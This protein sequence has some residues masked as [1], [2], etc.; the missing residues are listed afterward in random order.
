VKTIQ[1]QLYKRTGIAVV[2]LVLTATL[3]NSLRIGF[4]S[5]YNTMAETELARWPTEPERIANEWPLVES[6]LSISN[7]LHADNPLIISNLGRLHQFKDLNTALHYFRKASKLRPSHGM[8]W[9]Q[10]ADTKS[11]LNQFDG[12]F[13]NALSKAAHW[14]PWEPNAQY[15]TVRAGL[16]A[17]P[18]LA[19]EDRLLV[20]EVAVRGMLSPRNRNAMGKLLKNH[21]F[22]PLVCSSLPKS[23]RYS[24]YCRTK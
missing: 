11:G 20:R 13:S 17:W 9:A 10:I 7:I 6:N 23:R 18:E 12:E 8:N 22:L 4:S 21:G 15:L 14:G 16:R 3:F 5:I 1:P 19:S 24:K 2:I